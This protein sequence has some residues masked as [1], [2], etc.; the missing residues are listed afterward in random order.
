MM[1]FVIESSQEMDTRDQFI[2]QRLSDV[3]TADL[4]AVLNEVVKVEQETWPEEIQ[5]PLAKFQ[6][7]A[8]LFPEGFLT[9]A[10]A[11]L[12]IVGVSTS[13]IIN[14]S[15]DSN[16]T[17]EEITDHGWIKTTHN[18]EGNCL[19]LVSVG[20]SPKAQGQGVGSK[21][22][23]EQIKLAGEKNLDWLVLGSRLPGF[24]EYHRVHPEVSGQEYLNLKREDG[25]PLD[26]EIRFYTRAGF[27]PLKLVPNYM[28]DDPESE[29]FG[30]V[31]AWKNPNKF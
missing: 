29:N 2:T 10:L 15:A 12:G 9:I 3:P 1:S 8:Q 18:P 14:F 27:H 30:V 28:E 6:S 31:M 7:R 16:F 11:D 24:A 17:W 13:E 23:T 21:L 25:L 26:P 4:P 22:L 5:A 20:A 19:Y